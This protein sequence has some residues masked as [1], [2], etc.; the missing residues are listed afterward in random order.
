MLNKNNF[1]AVLLCS[2]LVESKIKPLS[3]KQWHQLILIL[4]KNKIEEPSVL[5][6]M[7]LWEIASL[8]EMSEKF[9]KQIYNRL[10]LKKNEELKQKLELLEKQNIKIIGQDSIDYPN[11]VLQRMQDNAPAFFYCVG[12]EKLVNTRSIAVVGARR[13]NQKSLEMAYKTGEQIA[14]EELTLV[15]GGAH[16]CDS[17]AFKGA[18]SVNGNVVLFLA[19][20]LIEFSNNAKIKSLINSRQICLLCDYNPFGKF[21]ATHALYRNQYIYTNSDLVVICESRNGVGGTFKGAATNLQTTK[22]P[23]YIL[24]D[25]SI[26]GNKI[27]IKN[28]AIPFDELPKSF[29]EWLS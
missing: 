13:A 19:V 10:E 1:V 12:N 28:G 24:N 2:D 20:P 8:I 21:T 17:A 7:P 11:L 25:N 18:L 5:V 27:L 15:S 23:T 16:G 14:S 26:L 22:V 6:D 9:A 3:I 4:I 29:N